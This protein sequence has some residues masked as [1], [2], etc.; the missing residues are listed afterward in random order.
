MPVDC[1]G[2]YPCD[3]TSH[4]GK[5]YYCRRHAEA[6]GIPVHP[7]AHGVICHGFHL[8]ERPDDFAFT[9]SAEP[10]SANP[11]PRPRTTATPTGSTEVPVPDMT[12]DPEART[13]RRFAPAW[14]QGNR[15]R[16][17][18]PA[19]PQA[20]ERPEGASQAKIEPTRPA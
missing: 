19:A 12:F 7:G 5:P 13:G 3:E 1:S 17:P 8:I 2:P 4:P 6:A 14:R 9:P 20:P 11:R 15:R 10:R 18:Y 16:Y